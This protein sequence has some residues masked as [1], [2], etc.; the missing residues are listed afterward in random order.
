M[1]G[2]GQD[3]YRSKALERL[4]SP[5]A[6]DQLLHV[7]GPRDWLPLIAVGL[8][9]AVLMSWSLFGTVPTTVEARGVMVF[10]RTIV[11]CQTFSAGR[12][13]SLEINPGDYV[14]KGGLLGRLDQSDLL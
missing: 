4:S 5:E 7:V 3:I 1:F 12:L 13:Q 6:V 14:Q 8:L 11:D 9:I 2:K 10:P